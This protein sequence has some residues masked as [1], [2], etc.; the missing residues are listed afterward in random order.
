MND[1]YIHS[2]EY[3]DKGNLVSLKIKRF[4]FKTEDKFLFDE[5]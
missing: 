5:N 2:K 3:V 4:K 1:K